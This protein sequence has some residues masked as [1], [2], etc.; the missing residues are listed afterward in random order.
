MDEIPLSRRAVLGS[1]VVGAATLAACHGGLSRPATGIAP[2]IPTE[3]ARRRMPTAFVGHGSPETALHAPYG[4]LWT[5]WA[6]AMPRPQAVLVF[7]AHFELRPITIGATTTQPLVYDFYGFD[8]PLYAIRYATPGAPALADRV[9]G[10]LRPLGSV[11]RMEDRGL[12]HG[13]W[14]PLK[15][16]YPR[17]DVPVLTVSIPTHDAAP[18]AKVGQALA[19]L[20]DE[21]VLLLGSGNVTHNLR[22]LS[23]PARG[24]PAWASDFDAWTADVVTRGDLDALVDYL[25]RS[26]SP[27]RSHPTKDHFVPL[28]VSAAAGIHTGGATTFPITGWEGG[29]ISRRCI[30]IG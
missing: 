10:L 24:T 5:A 28:I 2:A 22:S 16:M 15:W 7:S 19:P 3:P 1:A 21:G 8:D 30:Q 6:D 26:P 4:S 29:S 14:V 20:R 25:R 23:D 17:A 9:E 11:E 13:A 27:S 12:D 18:L